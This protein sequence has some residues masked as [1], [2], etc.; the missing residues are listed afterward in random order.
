MTEWDKDRVKSIALHAAA[1]A[2]IAIPVPFIG[3][4]LGAATMQNGW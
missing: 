4:I 2:V 1:G 3:P